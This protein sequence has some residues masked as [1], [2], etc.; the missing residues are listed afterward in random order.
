MT[1]KTNPID[2]AASMEAAGSILEASAGK[3]LPGHPESVETSEQHYS[4]RVEGIS[5]AEGEW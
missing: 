4:G 1:P 5:R 3:N 2:I